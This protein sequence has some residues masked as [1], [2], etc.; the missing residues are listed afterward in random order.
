MPSDFPRCE[1][2]P[3]PGHQ[4]TFRIDGRECLRWHHG[5]EYPRPFFFPLRG[6]SGSPL[7]RMGHPGAPNHDHHRS[8]WWAHNQV[9]G[10]DFWSENG[11]TR[12]QQVEW[13]T[14]EDGNQEARM[15]V[16]LHWLGREPSSRPLLTQTCITRV[17]PGPQPGETLVTLEAEWKPGGEQAVKVGMSN[18]GFLGIRMAKSISGYFGQGHISDSEG[19]MGEPAIFGQAAQWMDYSGPVPNE[20]AK[21]RP[22]VTEG[23][24]CMDHPENPGHPV[25]WHV[26][27]DGWMGPSATR[28]GDHLITVEKP[29][30][31]RYLLHAHGGAVDPDQADA[32]MMA[33]AQQKP[34]SLVRS[35]R[36]H[37][38]YELV[39]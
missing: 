19:R 30:R 26:R 31:L 35:R 27:E 14:Y 33:F 8:I 39:D 17:A 34:L 29:L 6:P 21:G 25:K 15:A 13:Q 32:L 12:I 24:T 4:V 38:Y 2:L 23:I 37:T 16:L 18:F 22:A 3:L 7:T 36:P 28:S 20:R 9:E 1:C 5:P 11:G 10:Q